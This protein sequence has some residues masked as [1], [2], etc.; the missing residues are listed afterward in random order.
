MNNPAQHPEIVYVIDEHPETRRQIEAILSND[1]VHARSF[2]SLV[3]FLQWVDYD[4]LPEHTVVAAEINL[5]EL[6]GFDLLNILKADAIFLPTILLGRTLSVNDAVEA[7][8]A[9][10][11]Y[12]LQKP[13]PDSAFRA[14]MKRAVQSGCAQRAPQLPGS[15]I[16]RK[17]SSLSQRQRELLFHVSNG[18]TN[19]EIAS[20]LS[21]SQKTVEL[22]RSAMMQKMG[23][24]SLAELIRIVV[25]CGDL[26][27]PVA[28]NDVA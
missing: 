13:F 6:G 15:P 16:R 18:R 20:R 17:L 12:I 3:T 9:G 24:S 14:A 11:S 26:L 1:S 2:A 27:Q 25:D 8:H 23:A 7:M 22:H 28:Q 4:R 5:P 10:A 19:R 21:I